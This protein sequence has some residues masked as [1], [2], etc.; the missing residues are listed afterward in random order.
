[1]KRDESL[2]NEADC[3]VSCGRIKEKAT[4]SELVVTDLCSAVRC[5]GNTCRLV[6]SSTTRFKA[7]SGRGLTSR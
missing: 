1:M 6:P 4:L 3:S 5:A 2:G 7:T